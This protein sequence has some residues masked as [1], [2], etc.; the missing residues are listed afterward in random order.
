MWLWDFLEEVLLTLGFDV[1][2]VA[3]IMECVKS[4]RYNMLLAGNKIS[5]ITHSRGLRQG[6]PLSPCL[7]VL[8]SDV[9]S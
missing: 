5:S 7:F 3:R 9:F 4:V 1:K 2:W 8:V 6:D